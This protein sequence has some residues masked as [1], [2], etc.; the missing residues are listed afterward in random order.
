MVIADFKE[1]M[2]NMVQMW[3][4]EE[5]EFKHVDEHWSPWHGRLHA[6]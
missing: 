5:E 3:V 6:E 4:K 1:R 2:E